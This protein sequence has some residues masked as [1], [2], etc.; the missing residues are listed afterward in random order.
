MQ[1]LKEENMSCDTI[2]VDEKAVLDIL[3][4]RNI[5][6]F[7][8]PVVS[9]STK[10]IV[11]FEAFSRGGGGD[12]CIIDPQLLFHDALT[13]NTKVEVDR[14]CREKALRQFKPISNNHKDMLLFL[15]VNSEI[16]PYVEA[17]SEVLKEQV[18]ALGLDFSSVVIDCNLKQAEGEAFEAFARL[19]MDFGFQLSLEN[20]SIGDPF[21]LTLPRLKPDFVKIDSSFFSNGQQKEYSPKLLEALIDI[22]DRAGAVVVAQGVET[23]EESI[24]L[25]TAGVHLQQGYYYTKDEGAK[26]K[27]PAKMFFD[28]I[29]GSY[30]KYKEE[31]RTLVQSRKNRFSNTFQ[32]VASIC[33]KFA[34][35]PEG[36][37]EEACKT[38]VHNVQDVVSMFVLN[39]AGIQVTARY[40]VRTQRGTAS[41]KVVG[42]AKGV[43][44]SMQDYVLYLDMGYE[45]FVTRPFLSH[46]ADVETC[47][48][49]RPLYNSEGQRFIVCTEL[50]YPGS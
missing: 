13:P 19:H 4:S 42:T 38:L 20:C 48:I 18:A 27:D 6:T 30:E 8:Q 39:S 15:N 36:R 32:N 12:V 40:H 21:S 28:K 17:G 25:L 2:Q 22:A 41:S 33:S 3:Q 37:F 26:T 35:L 44:H 31:K 49:S 34:S 1:A 7:F 9:I 24:R 11:G 46:Y 23:E 16:L 14:L 50:P 47:I 45:K 29:V 10:S 43:D 5:S